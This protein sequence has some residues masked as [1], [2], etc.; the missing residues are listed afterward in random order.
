MTAIWTERT[1]VVDAAYAVTRAMRMAEVALHEV[2]PALPPLRRAQ[3]QRALAAVAGRVAV[4]ERLLHDLDALVAVV[5]EEI[6]RGTHRWWHDDEHH[7]RGGWIESHRSPDADVLCRGLPV[8]RDL[9]DA[10][11]QMLDAVDAERLVGAL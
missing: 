4:N 2:I 9:R 11:A 8:I 7:V 3:G 5:H 10:I 1:Y 6:G